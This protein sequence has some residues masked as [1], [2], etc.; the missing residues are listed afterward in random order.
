MRRIQPYSFF[1]RSSPKYYLPEVQEDRIVGAFNFAKAGSSK[2]SI[3]LALTEPFYAR[4]SLETRDTIGKA[5]WRSPYTG[6]A[7]GW[8]AT[9]LSSSIVFY[10]LNP[11]RD[12]ED[13]NAPSNYLGQL[14]P[15]YLPCL[16][17]SGKT[18]YTLDSRRSQS[19]KDLDFDQACEAVEAALD[20][21]GFERME[22]FSDQEP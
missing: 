22:G 5:S 1:T 21:A 6:V 17:V 14:E 9:S 7:P 18:T 13:S 2:P 8:L 16:L 15:E 20:A 19:V 4:S 10:D 12:G 3:S 11:D